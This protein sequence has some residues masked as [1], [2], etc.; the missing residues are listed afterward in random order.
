[1][2]RK[3][4]RA[5]QKTRTPADSAGAL[6]AQGAAAQAAGDLDGA[7]RLYK[8]GLAIDGGNPAA[9]NN[10]GAALLALGRLPEASERFRQAALLQ[11]AA[12]DDFAALA[13]TLAQVCPPLAV[14]AARAEQAWPQRLALDALFDAGGFAAVAGDPLTETILQTTTVRVLGFERLLTMLRHALLRSALATTADAAPRDPIA[15]WCSLARQCFINEYVFDV[16]PDEEPAFEDLRTRLTDALATGATVPPAWLAAFA[17]YAPLD[18]LTDAGKLA[19]RKWP[20]PV[21]ALIRQQ[22]DEPAQ[23]RALK[24]SLKKLAAIDDE[25]SLRVQAQYEE[26]PYPRW[27]LADPHLRP[28]AIDDHLRATYPHAMFQPLGERAPLDILVAGCGTGRHAIGLARTY[29]NP[30]MLAVDLS[31]T[32]LA[33][34]IRKTPEDLRNVIDYAQA[35]ILKLSGLGRT[36]DLIETRGVLHHMRDPF[37]GWRALLPLLK[38]GGVMNVGL[39]SELARAD[40]VAARAFIAAEDFPPTPEGIRRCRQAMFAHPQFRQ[41]A[42]LGDFYSTSD[43]RDL[44]FHTQECRL[45]IPQIRDFLGEQKLAF[46]G[47]EFAPQTVQA[48]RAAFAQAGRSINNLDHWHAYESEHPDTFRAMYQFAVQKA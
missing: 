40:I 3:D 28:A 16:A 10:L 4:R 27:V 12:L 32:S 33:Y 20:E 1:M 35:D 19:G 2:N 47:F 21:R 15:F 6:F 9:L 42:L 18:N 34:A 44:L 25:V 24:S 11:P 48:L 17:C 31:A 26:S 38:S 8:R 7:I 5:T 13:G 22:V 36:F 14:A 39:Y 23:E 30:R 45:T 29:K 37:E 46:I 43:C 41:F